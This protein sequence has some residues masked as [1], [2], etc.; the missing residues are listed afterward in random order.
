MSY[1]LILVNLDPFDSLIDFCD[2]LAKLGEN[3]DQSSLRFVNE[4]LKSF[5]FDV[6][7]DYIVG[8]LELLN[9]IVKRLITG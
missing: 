1:Y 4:S 8:E 2:T 5:E 3:L 7:V 9:L 6:P